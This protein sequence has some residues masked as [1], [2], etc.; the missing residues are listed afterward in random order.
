M[1]T[2]GLSEL[3]K[4]EVNQGKKQLLLTVKFSHRINQGQIELK[5]LSSSENKSQAVK[6]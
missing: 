5:G 2:Y 3:Q 4:S 1:D 6:G